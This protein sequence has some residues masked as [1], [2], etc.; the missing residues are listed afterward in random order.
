MLIDTVG[1]SHL[2]ELFHSELQSGLAAW[3][4]THV[5]GRKKRKWPAAPPNAVQHSQRL[6]AQ[7]VWTAGSRHSCARSHRGWTVRRFL[8]TLQRLDR[9]MRNISL[10]QWPKN[11]S[12]GRRCLLRSI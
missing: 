8:M 9:R 3:S 10:A 1:R 7:K 11:H 12:L 4:T 5:A 2:L 6:T